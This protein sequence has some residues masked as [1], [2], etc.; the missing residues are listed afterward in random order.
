MAVLRGLP[1]RQR[2]DPVGV[3]LDVVV[4]LFR[5]AVDRLSVG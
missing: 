1:P 2:R 5:L 3:F 4:P